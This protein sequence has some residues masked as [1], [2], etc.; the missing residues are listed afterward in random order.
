MTPWIK[1]CYFW[2]PDWFITILLRAIFWRESD[3]VFYI[4]AFIEQIS[5]FVFFFYSYSG[6]W[7]PFNFCK[8]LTCLPMKGLH[9]Y[10]IRQSIFLNLLFQDVYRCS[11]FFIQ[12]TEHK[13]IFPL[14]FMAG[15]SLQYIWWLQSYKVVK[16]WLCLSASVER[17]GTTKENN[18]PKIIR[19]SYLGKCRLNNPSLQHFAKP[20]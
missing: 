15:V 2:P 16:M 13:A 6:I 5:R 17:A 20:K 14:Y 9:E 12:K 10:F 1:D 18:F 19:Q 4:E 3:A 8:S 7:I 11:Y